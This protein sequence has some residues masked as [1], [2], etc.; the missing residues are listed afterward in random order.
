V[1]GGFGGF[2]LFCSEEGAASKEGAQGW[3]AGAGAGGLGR[4]ERGLGNFDMVTAG[5]KGKIEK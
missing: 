3:G 1:G 4:Q 2:V 5:K